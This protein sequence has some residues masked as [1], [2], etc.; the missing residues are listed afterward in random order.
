MP[1]DEPAATTNPHTDPAVLLLLHGG[2]AESLAPQ[3][4]FGL[5]RLRMRVFGAAVER[6][7]GDRALVTV[8]VEYRHRGWNGRHAHPAADAVAAVRELASLAPRAGIALLGHSMGGRAAIAA[9]GHPHVLGAVLLAP[10]CE[11]DDPVAHL[12][13]KRIV[14]LHDPA[15][16]VTSAD[17]SRAF[18]ARARRAGADVQY[19]AMPHGGHTMIRGARTWHRLAARSVTAILEHRTFQEVSP[20]EP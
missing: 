8:E 11:D 13:G 10:W 19:M 9:A 3:P 16:R 2:K 17:K 4:R 12:H 20:N 15:D 7:T 5:A 6:R 18:A 14:I 1:A